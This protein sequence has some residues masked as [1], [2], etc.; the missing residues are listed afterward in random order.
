MKWI[1]IILLGA[2]WGIFALRLGR[3]IWLGRL[4]EVLSRR[5]WLQV[6]LGMLAFT[7]FGQAAEQVLDSIFFGRPITLYIKSI[8][9]LG[10]VYLYYLTLRDI[11][12]KANR[13]RYLQG[14]G[15]G[16]LISFTLIF[17]FYFWFPVVPEYDFRLVMIA[18]RESVICVFIAAALLP[19]TWLFLNHER[20][21]SMKIRHAASIVCCVGYLLTSVGSISAGIL[22]MLGRYESIEALIQIFLLPM[23]FVAVGFLVMLLPH[24]FF[25]V[26]D[27]PAKLW[28]YWRLR[29]VENRVRQLGNIPNLPIKKSLSILR[30]QNL[31]LAMY[32]SLIFILDYHAFIRPSDE[33]EVLYNQIQQILRSDKPYADLVDEI[34]KLI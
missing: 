8:A 12:P 26:A 29:R 33:G 32:R 21:S 31:E 19:N 17:G 34:T 15:L 20:V 27:Y 30:P 25:A 1:Y 11:D 18:Y 9:L 5:I 4:K 10:M 28:I 14:L 16:A 2:S 3:A 7:F 13:Y 22:V 6:F 23:Y 24:R